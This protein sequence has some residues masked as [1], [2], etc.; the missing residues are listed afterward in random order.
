MAH[1][2]CLSRQ[3]LPD[4][5]YVFESPGW[6]SRSV[7]AI[8]TD[9]IALSG[10]PQEKAETETREEAWRFPVGYDLSEAQMRALGLY[11]SAP[12]SP[13]ETDRPFPEPALFVVNP[14]GNI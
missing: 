10:D 3:A 6:T 1:A 4:L 9:V 8:N 5:P 7:P 14:Q 12:R 13:Q 2:C 11:I